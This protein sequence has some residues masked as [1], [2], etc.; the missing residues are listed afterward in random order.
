MAEGGP[1]S[2]VQGIDLVS[3][4]H[5]KAPEFL[6]K[7]IDLVPGESPQE[8]LDEIWAGL[9]GLDGEDLVDAVEDL[10]DD[11]SEGGDEEV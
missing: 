4:G 1:C 6:L 2:Q 8:L 10:L 11:V 3:H 5:L 9:A 7:R